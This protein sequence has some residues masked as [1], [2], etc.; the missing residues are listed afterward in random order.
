MSNARDGS[1]N[2][3]VRERLGVIPSGT[4]AWDKQLNLISWNGKE[5]PKFDIRAWSPEGDRMR[6]GITLYENEMREIVRLYLKWKDLKERGVDAK[7][8]EL[9][10]REA[11]VRE[12]EARLEAA[13]RVAEEQEAMDMRAAREQAAGEQAAS[14][15]ASSEE[16]WDDD[17]ET[18]GY[19]P[20][21]GASMVAE[22][23]DSGFAA[24]DEESP[25]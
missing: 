3:E 8:D 14:D 16:R 13:R 6:K 2:Y 11:A 22:S 15:E 21:D 18:S 19:K 1:I 10:A 23:G 4:D 12:A 17:S 9:K 25:F 5:P 24:V 20:E 7:E